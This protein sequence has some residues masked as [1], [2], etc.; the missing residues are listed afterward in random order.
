MRRKNVKK[1]FLVFLVLL[2]GMA[3]L[4]AMPPPRP[5]GGDVTPQIIIPQADIAIS[6]PVPGEQEPIS[7][8]YSGINAV[9]CQ[10]ALYLSPTLFV[11]FAT[12]QDN[13]AAFT[14]DIELLCSWSEQYREGLL[15][16]NDFK[17]LVSGRI[18]VMYMREQALKGMPRIVSL[19]PTEFPLLC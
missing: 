4:S 13:K 3:G 15:T 10:P 14:E 1:L 9:F 19:T 11:D 6:I 18:A 7:G 17:T 5:G 12:A 8:S 2:V 16:G